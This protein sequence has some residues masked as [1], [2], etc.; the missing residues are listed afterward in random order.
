MAP[1]AKTTDVNTALAPYAKTTDVNTALAPYAKTTD[2]NTALTG[3][4]KTAALSGYAKTADTNTAIWTALAGYAKTAD[5]TAAGNNYTK[6][7]DVNVG[8]DWKINPVGTELQFTRTGANST[9]ASTGLI[10]FS[11]DGNIWIN[12]GSKQG[13]LT[14]TLKDIETNYVQK[15]DLPTAGNTQLLSGYVPT[16]AV[17]VGDWKISTNVNNELLFTRSGG[18]STQADTGIIKFGKDGNVWSNRSSKQGWL[19]D[20]ISALD[21]RVTAL[22]TTLDTF[23]T[24]NTFNC[25]GGA[26]TVGDGDSATLLKANGGTLLGPYNIQF[27]ARD[28]ATCLDSGKADNTVYSIACDS[29]NSNQRFY[30]NPITGQLRSENGKCLDNMGVPTGGSDSAG[31]WKFNTCY[32]HQ[33]QQFVRASNGGIGWPD[34]DCLDTG[35]ASGHSACTANNANQ[36]VRYCQVSGTQ[37]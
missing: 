29:T 14:D 15:S 17:N 28:G 18:S 33:N 19:S 24:K 6:V 11:A 2:V 35:N 13:W 9:T 32:D 21:T 8:T 31:K 23:K 36:K 3:Y 5:V 12:K 22:G 1:Y 37:Y 4:A 7:S 20:S 30:T 34:S 26:C 10:R 25:T 16:S 27:Y